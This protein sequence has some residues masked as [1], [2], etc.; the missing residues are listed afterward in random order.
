MTQHFCVLVYILEAFALYR[1]KWKQLISSVIDEIE[2][3]SARKY[4]NAGQLVLDI[5]PIQ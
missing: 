5:K 3:I 1:G 2:H 4:N